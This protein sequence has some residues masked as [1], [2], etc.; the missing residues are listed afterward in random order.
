MNYSNWNNKVNFFVVTYGSEVDDDTIP[1]DSTLL[2]TEIFVSPAPFNP[3]L[4][5][6][7]IFHNLPADAE[8]KILNISKEL[9]KSLRSDSRG[10]LSWEGTNLYGDKVAPGVYL[11]FINGQTNNSY[12]IVIIR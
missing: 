12:K 1:L 11:Y 5:E 6:V 7:V 3:S 4:G 8:V 2:Q 10:V 9:I